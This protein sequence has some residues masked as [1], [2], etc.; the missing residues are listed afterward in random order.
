MRFL[1]LLI[2]PMVVFGTYAAD[3]S[4]QATLAR[5]DSAAA[6]YKGMRADIARVAHI[7][8]INDNTVENGKVA[9]RRP[10]SQELRMLIVTHPPNERKVLITPTKA[11]IYYP[12]TYTVEEYD[13][14]KTSNMTDELLLLSFGST[15]KELLTGYSVQ[16]GPSETVAGQKTTRL[17]LVPKAKKLLTVYPKIQLWI[18]D[19]TG[20][21][22]QQKLN[23]PNGKDY[24]QAT[25][26]NIQLTNV[27]DADLKLNVPG[28]ARRE[29]PL[30]R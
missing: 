24:N 13:F 22:V 2:A 15:S 3:N 16:V 1:H 27:S 29:N 21:T 26:S 7:D 12:K 14:G 19:D 11:E 4:L 23:E 28:N 9:V 17:D 25:Y 30:K 18:A 8:A 10:S 5:M 20:V 6:K